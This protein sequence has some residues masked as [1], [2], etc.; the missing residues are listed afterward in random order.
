MSVS[1]LP[2][3]NSPQPPATVKRHTPPSPDV[4]VKPLFVSS[5]KKRKRENKLPEPY[6]ASDVLWHDVQDLLGRDYIAGRMDSGNEWDAP[7]DLAK[8]E[9]VIVR[10]ARFA[11]AGM[12]ICLPVVVTSS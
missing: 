6:S 12:A 7:G 10:I 4:P 3:A 2:L 5:K 1:T 8:G 9:E 11:V